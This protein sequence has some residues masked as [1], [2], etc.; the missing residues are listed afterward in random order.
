MTR[1]IEKMEVHEVSVC[2]NPAN[3]DARVA[4]TKRNE[5][6]PLTREQQ[7]QA[8]AS[9]YCTEAVAKSASGPANEYQ[10]YRKR[11][12]EAGPR[13]EPEPPPL[14]PMNQ[15][16]SKLQSMAKRA[17]AKDPSRTTEQHFARLGEENPAL[18]AKAIRMTF[19]QVPDEDDE[20]PDA[21]LDDA[22]PDELDYPEPDPADDTSAA[23]D[24][25]GA[26]P[27]A[28]EGRTNRGRSEAPYNADGDNLR[29]NPRP[30]VFGQVEGSYDPRRRPA[31]AT[32]NA[33]NA[34]VEK[35]VVKYMARYPGASRVEATAW[36]TK[37][38]RVRR[39]FNGLLN[40]S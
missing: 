9:R 37:G 8:A 32:R 25:I 5:P 14:A 18:L 15:S 38:R 19:Q 3:E 36:A 6:T 40:A 30:A 10:A 11:L 35:R 4:M 2:D 33:L 21:D 16:F 22:E 24:G 17:A 1:L 27:T 28:A 23:H 29:Q 13:T 31:S 12:F 34:A 7:L 20:E 39:A 26:A